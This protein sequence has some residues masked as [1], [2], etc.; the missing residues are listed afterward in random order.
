MASG[1]DVWPASRAPRPFTKMQMAARHKKPELPRVAN[2]WP[3]T[4]RRMTDIYVL[5]HHCGSLNKISYSVH[6]ELML[7]DRS[8]LGSKKRDKSA[9][10]ADT[11]NRLRN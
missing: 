9:G 3:K 6:P 5:L 7:E 4:A 1:S 8:V 11:R 2:H 10:E